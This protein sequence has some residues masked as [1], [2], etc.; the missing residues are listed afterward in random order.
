MRVQQSI[1]RKDQ[2]CNVRRRQLGRSTRLTRS[3]SHVC[4]EA[5]KSE[6]ARS[7]ERVVVDAENQ[8]H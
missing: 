6:E 2:L 5:C 3:E 7:Q 8:I 1:E 4:S